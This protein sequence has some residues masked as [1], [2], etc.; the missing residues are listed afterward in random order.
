M[1][2]LLHFL[3]EEGCKASD[4]EH[5]IVSRTVN[6]LLPALPLAAVVAETG[7]GALVPE[8]DSEPGCR[9]LWRNTH[10][11]LH[12]PPS[13]SRLARLQCCVAVALRLRSTDSCK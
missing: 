1:S 8:A 6:V 11:C 13:S 5:A 4:R 10:S 7:L 12:T 9:D 2:S 3:G